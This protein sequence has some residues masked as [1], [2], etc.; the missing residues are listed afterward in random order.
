MTNN[1]H[2]RGSAIVEFTLAGIPM[3]FLIYLTIQLSI[4]MWNYHTLAYA[5]NEGSAYASVRGQGCTQNGNTC[6]TT[7]GTLATQIASAAIGIPADQVSVTLTTDSGQTIPCAPLNSCYSNT[8]TWPPATN[9]D[10]VPGKK[11]TIAAQ[12]QFPAVLSVFWPGTSP[13][14]FGTISLPSRSTVQI[15]F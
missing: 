11:I 6:S 2:E 1:R 10:N 9:S 15:L 8:T 7:V 14:R 4:G 5:V 12:Y 3:I 13:S